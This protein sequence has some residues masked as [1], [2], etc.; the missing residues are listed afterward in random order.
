[1][2]LQT[3]VP[4]WHSFTLTYGI[5]N[6]P[7]FAAAGPGP[8]TTLST[9]A[10]A[11]PLELLLELPLELLELLLEL[12]ELLLEVLLELPE[13]LPE[14]L[15]LLTVPPPP[16]PPQPATR[17]APTHTIQCKRWFMQQSRY[18]SSDTD[19]PAGTRLG[20]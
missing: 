9:L 16:P 17:Q 14:L 11:A 18:G 15:V 8:T 5:L 3:A 20:I 2:V 19:T 1:M 7:P 12:L 6:V 13:L 10:V 4:G